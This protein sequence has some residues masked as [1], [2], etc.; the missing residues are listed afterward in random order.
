VFA[1]FGWSVAALA[2]FPIGYLYFALPIW[3]PFS[4][5][6]QHLTIDAVGLLAT[7][8]GLPA[9]VEGTLVHVPE[10]V[11]E[12]ASGCSGLQMFV[13]GLAL[14]ALQG[15]LGYEAPRVRIK[16]LALMAILTLM[17]N[18]VRVFTI[19][20]A[21]HLTDMKHYLVTVD[22]YF[23][24]WVLFGGTLAIFMWMTRRWPTSGS[25]Q[26]LRSPG[27]RDAVSPAACVTA[28]VALSIVPLSAYSLERSSVRAAAPA[29]AV[30][31]PGVG[32]WAGPLDSSESRW[33]PAFTGA[34]ERLRAVY[35]DSAGR[36]VAVFAV[37][38]E[39]Q[40]QSAKLVSYANSVAGE[41]G[42]AIEDERVISVAG[43]NF[44]QTVLSERNGWRAVIWWVYDVDGRA[45]VNPLKSQLWYGIRSLTGPRRASL[46][47]FRAEC[48]PGCDGARRDL[49]RFVELMDPQIRLGLRRSARAQ[50]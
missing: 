11:F 29:A 48:R 30:L 41:E 9:Q 7:L 3:T 14:A 37:I 25:G 40:R 27:E 49:S 47:A 22:H 50:R 15:H 36:S 17:C 35:A 18:W 34:S 32:G 26:Y 44:R 19:V 6:L 21:G 45:F 24:G 33:Q 23:F 1:A 20:V 5:L 43:A 8:T 4:G 31:P 2:A 13:A 28:A 38:Y 42:V 39:A 12:V 16:R 46:R 10:G